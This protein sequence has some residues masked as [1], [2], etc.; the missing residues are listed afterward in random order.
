MTPQLSET[1]N[2]PEL[3]SRKRFILSQAV[4]G[5]YLAKLGILGIYD[6]VNQSGF[7]SLG[8]F[9]LALGL[10][11]AFTLGASLKARV[12]VMFESHDSHLFYLAVRRALVIS[13]I[14]ALGLSLV[15]VLGTNVIVVGL[16]VA[17]A[18]LTEN[19]TDALV[20]RLQSEGNTAD[21]LNLQIYRHGLV[22][23]TYI[24]IFVIESLEVA[25]ALEVVV[26]LIFAAPFWRGIAKKSESVPYGA[27]FRGAS[28]LS[29]SALLNGLVKVIV[30]RR[31][32]ST[33]EE[34]DAIFVSL[35]LTSLAL[36]G[37]LASSFGLYFQGRVER[38]FSRATKA[39]I[40]IPIAAAAPL[41]V[42]LLSTN[43]QAN[44]LLAAMLLVSNTMTLILKQSLM[45]RQRL[46][47][48]VTVHAVDFAF[49]LGSALFIGGTTSALV[50]LVLSQSLKYLL[51]SIFWRG[52]NR[53]RS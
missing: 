19:Q 40:L 36:T 17:V 9:S 23:L 31:L 12:L 11:N 25:L 1:E 27:V 45:L 39:K 16:L 28:A 10:V 34:S 5:L 2:S 41:V 35:V 50:V 29:V 47:Q 49:V 15:A 7:D 21:S 53:E 8:R 38:Y 46:S 13:S 30:L 18:R 44:Y 24:S 43:E 52:P 26:G 22:A 33:S 48:L 14:I 37:R 20:G 42:W 3:S 6:I 51:F 32:L 4:V